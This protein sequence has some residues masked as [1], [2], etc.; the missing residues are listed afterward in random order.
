MVYKYVIVVPVFRRLELTIKFLESVQRN[1]NVVL[2]II[3]DDSPDREH[4]NYFSNSSNIR[5]LTTEQEAW[6]CGCTR[7]GLDYVDTLDCISGETILVIANN[8]VELGDCDWSSLDDLLEQSGGMVHPITLDQ[9]GNEISSGCN[10]LSWFPYVTHH[11]KNI[12]ADFVNIDLCTA[13]FLCL[14]YLD[15]MKI[16]N[17]SINLTQYHGDND[18]SLRA[19]KLGVSASITPKL[20]C[21]VHNADTGMKEHNVLKISEL[22][23]SFWDIKSPNNID[24][25]FRFV[26]NHFNLFVSIFICSSMFT[27]TVAKFVVRK[28]LK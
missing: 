22:F 18:F 16:G 17:I 8:D 23:K 28:F 14:K 13:R 6:W 15:Y 1:L 11:P 9:D 25:R 4:F 26:S 12:C 5:V 3:V 27:N 19:K 7:L 20:F 24:S 10:V 2:F 21:T